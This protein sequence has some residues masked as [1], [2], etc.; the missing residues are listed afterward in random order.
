M[1]IYCDSSFD[2]RNKIAGVGI[3]IVDGQKRRTFSN[4]VKART[5]NEAELFAIYLAGIL[6]GG[7][8]TIYTDS[9]VAIS[10]IE[11]TI[12]DKNRTREQFLNHKYC[13]YWAYHI[14]KMGIIPQKIKAHQHVFQT[15]SMGNRMADLL[16]N[17]GRAKYYENRS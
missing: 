9:Q 1:I 15:H 10:Y 13:E 12:K 17:E 6:S 7:K 16:A 5:N 2:E 3:T 4:W 8:G 11:N 14:R